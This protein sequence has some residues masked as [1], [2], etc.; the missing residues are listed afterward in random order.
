MGRRFRFLR[1][2]RSFDQVPLRAGGQEAPSRLGSQSRSD[3]RGLDG[4]ET[5]FWTALEFRICAEFAGFED[6]L[7]RRH[8]CDGLVP[9]LYDL[10]AEEPCIRGLAYCGR[11]GQERWRFTLLIGASAGS[12]W[13]STGLH[14]CHRMR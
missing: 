6:G 8:W 13:R 5:A 2:C 11:S 7:L 14:C 10:Q 4:A 12:P 1:R 3:G 9:D